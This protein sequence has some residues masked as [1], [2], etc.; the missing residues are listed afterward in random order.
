MLTAGVATYRLWRE[1][2]GAV[3]ALMAGPQSRRVQRAGG[4]RRVSTSRPPSIWCRFRAEAMQAAVPPGQGAMAAILGSRGHR[5]RGGLRR[6]R[7]GRSGGGGEFQCAGPGGDRRAPRGGCARHRGGHRQG[8]AARDALPISVPAHSSL[9]QPAAER[10]RERLEERR[11]DAAAAGIR[12]LRRR[13]QNA[14]P[15]PDGYS[16]RPWSNSCIRP[17][18]GPPPCAP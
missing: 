4:G 3:P 5:R 11:G 15:R 2:G 9:M 10:L 16:R 8:R 14:S 18:I 12:G 13:R 1:R 17:C 6:G 7:A